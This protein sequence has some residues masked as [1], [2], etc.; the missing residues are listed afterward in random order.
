V[1]A[2]QVVLQF[3]PIDDP[4]VPA[5]SLAL[6]RTR[7]GSYRGTGANLAFD[8]RWQVTALIQRGADSVSVPLQLDVAGP[9]MQ[10]LPRREASGKPYHV[11]IVPF[12]GLF[13]IDLEPEQ[14]GPSTLTIGCYDRIFDARP[15]DS[16]VVTHEAPGAPIRQ[17]S[18]QRINRFQFVSKVDLAPGAN[19]ITAVTHGADGSRTRTA[20]DVTI[21]K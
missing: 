7:D 14:A 5:T 10:V 21:E 9:A 13:R 12:V 16:I 17:L 20:F 6:E 8:G 15:I 1:D 18:L 3:V 11:A 4:D 19:R 2:K